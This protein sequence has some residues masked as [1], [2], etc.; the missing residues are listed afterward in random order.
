M[1]AAIVIVAMLGMVPARSEDPTSQAPRT[2]NRTQENA[3]AR[4]AHSE[5][6]P[7]TRYV[8]TPFLEPDRCATAWVI[9]RFVD[10]DAVFEFYDRERMP[11]GVVLYDLPEAVLKRD[12]RRATV[13][14]L[15]D[16]EHISDPFV[17]RLGRLVHDIEVN[18][19]A[20]RRE[21]GS[22]EFEESLRHAMQEAGSPEGGL[23]ACFRL[24]DALRARRGD[25]GVW[26]GSPQ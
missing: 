10:P 4:A 1:F 11:E 14:V 3:A 18:A 13:E 20:S 7:P 6:V 23:R 2:P 22:L 21:P 26:V 24:L 15:I 17:A 19:W 16:E 9:H 12:A 25:V 5:S 8:T